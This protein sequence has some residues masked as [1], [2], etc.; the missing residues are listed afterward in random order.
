MKK[1][2][3]D[4]FS[5]K[6]SPEQTAQLIDWLSDHSYSETCDLVAAPPPDGFGFETSRAVLCRF[7]KAHFEEIEKRRQEKFT[8]RALDQLYQEFRQPYFREVL[9]ESADLFLQER[10]YEALTRPL[11]SIDD[12]KK[13]VGIA[14]KIK[15]LNLELTPYSNPQTKEQL[16]AKRHDKLVQDLSNAVARHAPDPS[17]SQT[18]TP[19]SHPNTP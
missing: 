4:S 9:A 12:L 6:I 2:R 1:Q 18:G 3:S 19:F 8:N 7:Y 5:E 15:E 14:A 13:L 10:Y 16:L 11:E 17:G